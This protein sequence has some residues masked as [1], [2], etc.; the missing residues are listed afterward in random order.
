MMIILLKILFS[1]FLVIQ[2]V[3]SFRICYNEDLKFIECYCSDE[4][5][6]IFCELFHQNT[7]FTEN[8]TEWLGFQNETNVTRL[9]FERN[10]NYIPTHIFN[11]TR[12]IN[13]FII[14][15]SNIS[16][17]P[18]FAFLHLNKLKHITLNYDRI[19][20]IAS[21]AFANH[22]ELTVID[23]ESNYISHIGNNA[24]ANLTKLEE[25]NFCN[26]YLEE[27]PSDIFKDLI[28]LKRIYLHSN[29]LVK[30]QRDLIWPII[31]NFYRD[32]AELGFQCKYNNMI[33]LSL[34]CCLNF[35][36]LLVSQRIRLNA[37]LI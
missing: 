6:N 29:R 16:V 19:K 35:L 3:N 11:Y 30:F 28:S 22:P 14:D 37:T 2:M 32:D 18:S 25:L 15:Y 21:S 5:A 20:I 8:N 31:N 10:F 1:Y 17:V 12:N 24:F 34:I 23:L 7:I 4:G 26:N 36:I 9:H 33:F 13:T 27:L